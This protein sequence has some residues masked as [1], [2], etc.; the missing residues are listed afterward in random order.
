MVL[1]GRNKTRFAFLC[2][3]GAGL[4]LFGCVPDAPEGGIPS[5]PDTKF[6]VTLM[7][8]EVT[9]DAAGNDITDLA[10]YR[11]YFSRSTPVDTDEADRFDAGLETMATVPGLEAGT[12]YFAVAAV[13]S[14]GNE[15]DLSGE[16]AAEV[17]PE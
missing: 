16:L 2:L 3:L 1:R 5:G 17:G 6:D 7:W 12:W 9:K 15:S 14:S 11:V 8:D 13:D 4:L 10:S